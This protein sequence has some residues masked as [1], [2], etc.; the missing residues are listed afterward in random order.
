MNLKGVF[1]ILFMF[2]CLFMLFYGI[3]NLVRIYSNEHK[4]QE[5]SLK[6]Y[7]NVDDVFQSTPQLKDQCKKFY[8]DGKVTEG[9]LDQIEEIFD[10]TLKDNF[11][12]NVLNASNK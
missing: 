5:I 11:F 10:K 7:K 2:S 4:Q 6:N 3:M 9:E 1:V 12:N 8:E